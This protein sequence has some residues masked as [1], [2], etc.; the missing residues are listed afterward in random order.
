MLIYVAVLTKFVI[1]IVARITCVA[2][3]GL[4][5]LITSCHRFFFSLYM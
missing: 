5:F 1:R 3:F 4:L 2:L